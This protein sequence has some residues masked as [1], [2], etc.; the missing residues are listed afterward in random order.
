MKSWDKFMIPKPFA[1]V[2]VTFCPLLKVSSPMGHEDF[3]HLRKR[4]ENVLSPYL[5]R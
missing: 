5:F 3:E 2:T 4:L 1:R